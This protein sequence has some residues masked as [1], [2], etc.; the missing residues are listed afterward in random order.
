MTVRYQVHVI[1][2]EVDEEEGRYDIEAED[3]V[4][5]GV[6]EFDSYEE[7]KGV[8]DSHVKKV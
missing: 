1:L 2:V 7:A 3:E 6:K 8:Y 4:F 5:D